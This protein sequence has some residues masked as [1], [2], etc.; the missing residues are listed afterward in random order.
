MKV[1]IGQDSHRFDL[2]NI[3]NKKLILGG[4]VFDGEPPLEANSDGD[5]ILHAITN[6]I[7]G[8]TCKNVLGKV[9]DEMC[10]QGITD[11]K[12]YLKKALEDLKETI[13][14]ISISIEGKTPKFYLRIDDS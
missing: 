1:S 4:I 3:E 2:K 9:A 5:V 10:K 7:S 6:A 12:E 8:I 11:S 13:A 14:H